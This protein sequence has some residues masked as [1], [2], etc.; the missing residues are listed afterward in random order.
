MTGVQ[1]RAPRHGA[2]PRRLVEAWCW[3]LAFASIAIGLIATLAFSWGECGRPL[4]DNT[5]GGVLFEASR[6]R[7][8][9]PL[10]VDPVVGAFDYGPVPARYFVMYPP[11]MPWLVSLLPSAGALTVARAFGCACWLG[12]L[13]WIASR[14][15]PECRRVAWTAAALVASVYALAPF[16]AS[17]RP[18]SLALL[19]AGLGLCRSV[20]LGRVDP[21]SATLFAVAPWIKPNIL[22]LAV[23]AMLVDLFL[24]RRRALLPIAVACLVTVT[25]FGLLWRAS[26]GAILTHLR[27]SMGQPA[28]LTQW[29]AQVPGRLQFFALPM[30]FAGL[31]GW[32]ARGEASV[33]IALGALV[34][35]FAWA[36]LSVAKI[37]S[38]ACYWMEACVAAVA[39]LSR[40]PVPEPSGLTGLLAAAAALVQ[41]LWIDV[42]SV[43]STVEAMFDQVP[44]EERAIGRARAVCGARDKELVVADD[45]GVE[46]ALNGRI[47]DQPFQMTHLVRAGLYPLKLW[48]ADIEREEVVGVVLRNDLL[49]RPLS[50]ESA[51]YDRFGPEMRRVLR[52]R[53]HLADRNGEWRTYCAPRDGG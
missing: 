13:A 28:S 3:R 11:I 39:V 7:A 40:A 53:F 49:E 19:L 45:V 42:A 30:I 50:S 52:E 5:E 10:Y 24:R 36:L 12:L 29:R 26:H 6:L 8:S 9:L 22:A 43:R 44:S 33:R 23:G 47:V 37:G 14:A 48:A 51:E 32:R 34:A 15:T 2:R 20:R 1:E 4:A 38:S 21:L 25:V 46:F 18:D 27:M 35:S 17:A 31:C 41:A 16:A